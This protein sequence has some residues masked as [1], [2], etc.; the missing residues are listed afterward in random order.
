M[1]QDL[2]KADLACDIL[3]AAHHGRKSGFHQEAVETMDPSIVICS[4]G[5]KPDTDASSGYAKIADSVLSTRFHGTIKL[6]MWG[7]GE[8]SVKN[9]K[10][11]PVAT[12]SPLAA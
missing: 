2:S 7:D 11:E 6:T 8:V 5:Q 3:K 10:G 4:V 9:H 12:L 1:L